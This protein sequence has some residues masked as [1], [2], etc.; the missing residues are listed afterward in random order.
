MLTLVAF[1]VS[2]L[3]VLKPPGSI[4]VGLAEM[5]PVTCPGSGSDEMVIETSAHA[6]R[7]RELFAAIRHFHSPVTLRSTPTVWLVPDGLPA[8]VQL[9]PGLFCS[10]L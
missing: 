8:P 1:L 10:T 2:Q 3:K 4:V 6:P 5:L 7:P 9:P